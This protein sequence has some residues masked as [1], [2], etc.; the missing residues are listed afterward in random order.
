MTQMLL[1]T[2]LATGMFLLL[3]SILSFTGQKDK[4]LVVCALALALW[5]LAIGKIVSTRL[6]RL[7]K[8]AD[9]TDQDTPLSKFSEAQFYHRITN[10]QTV[11]LSDHEKLLGDGHLSGK[12]N[13][14][15]DFGGRP[16]WLRYEH[17]GF[18]LDYPTPRKSWKIEPAPPDIV[19][20]ICEGHGHV[21]L[22]T[23]EAIWMYDG[24]A[25]IKLSKSAVSPPQPSLFGEDTPY[26]EIHVTEKSH[27]EWLKSRSDPVLWHLAT[28]AA[29]AYLGDPEEFV[30]WLIQQPEMDRAT[31][32]WIYLWTGGPEHLTSPEAFDGLVDTGGTPLKPVLDAICQRSEGLGFANNKIGTDQEFEIKRQKCEALI[33]AGR[34]SQSANIPYALLSVPLKAHD[35]TE[36]DWER[37]LIDGVIVV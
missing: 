33:K 8:S 2:L 17:D 13:P 18:Y 5:I 10:I 32:A 19:S 30:P 27:V 7:N 3:A 24:L 26:S 29:L 15:R 37:H 1:W 21:Q 22:K 28:V 36:T 11:S 16:C 25:Q 12:A 9:A 34:V 14:E 31:A 35:P 6:S 20:G 4:A 23:A